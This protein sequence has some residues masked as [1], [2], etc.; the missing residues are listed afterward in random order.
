MLITPAAGFSFTLSFGGREHPKMVRYIRCPHF[1]VT[2][3]NTCEN[4]GSCTDISFKGA[5][6]YQHG[7][8]PLSSIAENL[9]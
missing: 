3:L 2:G 1:G 7:T 8:K 9:L 4:P 5:A 6:C